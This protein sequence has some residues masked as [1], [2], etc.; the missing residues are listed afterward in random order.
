MKNFTIFICIITLI[1]SC[2]SEP[3]KEKLSKSIIPLEKLEFSFVEFNSSNKIDNLCNS[4]IKKF[5]QGYSSQSASDLN[6]IFNSLKNDNKETC[7]DEIADNFLLELSNNNTQKIKRI[8]SKDIDF[9]TL[10]IGAGVHSSII[11][12]NT[13]NKILIVDEDKYPARHFHSYNFRLNSSSAPYDLNYF[14][15]TPISTNKHANVKNSGQDIYPKSRQLWNQIIFNF[16][17][18]N[19]LLWLETKIENIER[20]DDIFIVKLK[21]GNQNITILV[22]KIILTTGLGEEVMPYTDEQIWIK[23]QKELLKNNEQLTDLPSVITYEDLFDL[24]VEMAKNNKSIF[25]LLGNK[26]IGIAGAGDSAKVAMEFLTGYAPSEAYLINKVNIFKAPK[27]IFWFGQ[28]L[29]TFEDFKK[30]SNGT[31]PRYN[32]YGFEKIFNDFSLQTIEGHIEKIN[33][34]KNKVNVYFP[35][36]KE[37]VDI[38]IVAIGYIN[39]NYNFIKNTFT[40]FSN[41]S[42]VFNDVETQ[43]PAKRHFSSSLEY[44]AQQACF[45]DNDCLEVYILGTAVNKIQISKSRINESYTKNTHSIEILS[46]LTQA[47]TKKFLN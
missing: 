2:A 13:Q 20:Y 30:T 21:K 8:N 38:L 37:E 40:D 3:E 45:K 15:N 29:S 7:A 9:E 4:N 42:L 19:C 44:V 24:H 26:N 35:K 22:K 1:T 27:N 16:F 23:S 33:S 12:R 34:N 18:S 41:K 31:K 32:Y 6:K 17:I 10:V 28:K 5:H 25:E 39:K 43:I 47:F 46:P 14:P 36:G 11:A